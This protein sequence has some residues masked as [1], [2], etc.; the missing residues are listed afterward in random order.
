MNWNGVVLDLFANDA[1]RFSQRIIRF[2]S[3]LFIAESENFH[4]VLE[5]ISGDAQQ[6]GCFLPFTF[7]AAQSLKDNGPSEL[8]GKLGKRLVF[9]KTYRVHPFLVLGI[10][11]KRRKTDFFVL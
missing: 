10:Y 6:A 4:I 2:K 9:R 7:G 8:V 3:E 5:G 1:V 11:S